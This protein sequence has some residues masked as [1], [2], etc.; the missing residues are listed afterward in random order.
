[1]S[2]KAL[3]DPLGDGQSMLFEALF[4]EQAMPAPLH[5]PEGLVLG[6]QAQNEFSH[7]LQTQ[8]LKS[9]Q[10]VKTPF[11]GVLI[12]TGCR[13]C[14]DAT[15]DLQPNLAIL[16]DDWQLDPGLSE[17]LHCVYCCLYMLEA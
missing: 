13:H 9:V 3:K 7:T 11:E 2:R 16:S 1:M 4:N 6:W 17:T 14:R 10:G 12:V 5:L 8:T 15:N